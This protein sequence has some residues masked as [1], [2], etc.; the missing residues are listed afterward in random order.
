MLIADDEAMSLGVLEGDETPITDNRNNLDEQLLNDEV[1]G[2]PQDIQHHVASRLND[3]QA[4]DGGMS[5]ESVAGSNPSLSLIG[6]LVDPNPPSMQV[7]MQSNANS[8]S[9]T[10]RLTVPTDIERFL[11]DSSVDNTSGVPYSVRVS[12]AP[13]VEE[14]TFGEPTLDPLSSV[15]Q[16]YTDATEQTA[17]LGRASVLEDG[18][19]PLRVERRGKLCLLLTFVP[20]IFAI[21]IAKIGFNTRAH[22]STPNPPSPSPPEDR[23]QVLLRCASALSHH[24]ITEEDS[25]IRWN[26]TKLFMNPAEKDINLTDCDQENSLFSIA[27]SMY[28]LRNSLRVPVPSWNAPIYSIYDFCSWKRVRCAPSS[29]GMTITHLFLNTAD[30]GGTLPPEIQWIRGLQWL[31]ICANSGVSGPIPSEL[32]L[33][34]NLQDLQIQTT[35]IS[36]TIPTDLGRLTSLER[37]FL[38]DTRLSGTMPHEICELPHLV[39]LKTR[40]QVECSCCT[41]WLPL[42]KNKTEIKRN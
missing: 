25:P 2:L 23:M 18:R 29:R 5:E 19:A 24:E 36:G 12:D 22:H 35:R 34:P 4:A 20:I 38:Y 21:L 32:G 3:L 39:T 27:Y 14:S 15:T 28:V 41:Q 8:T 37:F 11:N 7:V 17:S 33:L 30:I 1:Q 6:N 26:V 31:Q 10:S 9:A 13:E 16:Q 40:H 42:G